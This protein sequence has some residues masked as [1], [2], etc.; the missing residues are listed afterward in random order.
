VTQSRRSPHRLFLLLAAPALTLLALAWGQAA[1]LPLALWC[2]V[3]WAWSF[4]RSRFLMKGLTAGRVVAPAA[5]EDDVVHVALA[6]ENRGS[7]RVRFLRVVDRFSAA[8]A[9][10]QVIPEAGPLPARSLRPLRYEAGCSRLWGSY[11]VGPLRLSVTDALGLS[12]ATRVLPLSAE[13]SV[14]PK[15]HDV[16]GL[17]QAGGRPSLSV[18]DAASDLPGQSIDYL[19]VR[20]Y[21]PGDDPRRI[22]WQASARTGTLMMRE[23]EIDLVPYLSLFLDVDRA[24]RAGLGRKST[25]EY[26]A[27]VGASLLATAA[28]RGQIVQLFADCD[29]PVF[30]PPGRGEAHLMLALERLIHVKQDG[31]SSIFEA[32]TDRLPVLPSGSMVV[33]LLATATPETA[34]LRV[35][36]ERLERRHLRSAFVLV[37]ARTFHQLDFA[38]EEAAELDRRREEAL[39]LLAGRDIPHAVLSGEDEL[40]ERLSHGLFTK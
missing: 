10:L 38:S 11:A 28:R 26:V 13:F 14:F 21:F 5:F 29:E 4:L 15:V 19:G 3:A 36:L 8:I 16:A 17:V 37:D 32:V 30:V 25:R 6:V 31:L 12:S 1:L 7:A 33:V 20:E 2:V 39:Q 35:L 24:H 34:D 23:T 9:E 40:E 27:R 22:H 18:E